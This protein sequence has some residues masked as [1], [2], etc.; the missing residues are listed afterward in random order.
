MSG[1]SATETYAALRLEIDNW[2]WTGVP[3]LIRTGKRLP[4][5]QT[6]VRVVLHR[7]PPLPFSA[8]DH[9]GP[10]PTSS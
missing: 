1:D 9:A 5:T 2:R 8:G 10:S 7:P 6:E 4:V 3:F